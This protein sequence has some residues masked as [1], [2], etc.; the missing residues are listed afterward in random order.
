ML[1]GATF[2]H[3]RGALAHWGAC[4]VIWAPAREISFEASRMVSDAYVLL[5]RR[6]RA[7]EGC[8]M[9]AMGR[10]HRRTVEPHCGIRV[11]RKVMV[12]R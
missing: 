7:K 12:L 8:L 4:G 6:P 10:L 5:W 2:S 3:E 9:K 1:E 11:I